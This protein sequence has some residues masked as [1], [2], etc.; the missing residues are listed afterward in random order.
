MGLMKAEQTKNSIPLSLYVHI[1]WCVRKCPYCDFNSHGM[2]AD[3]LPES[4]YIEA[5]LL[6][7]DNSLVQTQQRPLG[8]IFFG[9]GTPSLFSPKAIEQILSG[10]HRNIAFSP[11]IEI[12]LETNPGT[13]EHHHFPD[14]RKAGINRISIGAQ[15]FQNDKLKRLG[16]IHS[17]DELRTAIKQVIAAGFDNVNLDIMY[18][19]P[20]QTV[21][22]AMLDLQEALSFGL[23]HLSWYHLTL[24]PNTPFYR[25]PPPLPNE[26]TVFAIQTAGTDI[27]NHHGLAQYEVSAYAKPAHRCV[28]NLNYWQFGD[29]IGIGAGAHGKFTDLES[30]TISRQQKH[31]HP[32]A[33]MNATDKIMKQHF[34]CKQEQR[35][36]FM[37]NALRLTGG[38]QKNWFVERTFLTLNDVTVE[39]KIA[40]L[41]AKGLLENHLSVLKPTLLGQ[42]FLNEL[43]LEFL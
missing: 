23:P 26:D 32:K 13:V 4:E 29:Y 10:I 36:E 40:T 37:L 8:S 33:Y 39:H 27:L 14:Y 3:T 1:P 34:V 42:K 5:L 20:E 21:A 31:P 12:T 43:T 17:G 35:F 16:R 41:V 38:F 2:K 9:G 11:D 7:L 28:H 19:L 15:S 24:E 30:K 22:E 6:D 25:Q 18:G